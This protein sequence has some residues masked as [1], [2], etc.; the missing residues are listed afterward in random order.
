MISGKDKPPNI[1]YKFTALVVI[2]RVAKQLSD[3][4]LV[5]HAFE[6]TS[7]AARA[8]E[9]AREM[10]AIAGRLCRAER[11]SRVLPSLSPFMSGTAHLA[12]SPLHRPIGPGQTTYGAAEQ[13]DERAPFQLTEVHPIPN[14]QKERGVH[15]ISDCDGSV[16]GRASQFFW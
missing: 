5:R 11:P 2:S 16:S 1:P 13:R 3:A 15:R 14:K 7:S 8:R 4:R 9:R 10:E 12:V 6:E